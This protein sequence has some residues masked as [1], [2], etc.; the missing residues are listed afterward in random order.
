MY[1]S[2]QEII[3]LEKDTGKSFWEIVRDND[4]RE[5]EITEEA[6]FQRMQE[7]YEAMRNA[8]ASYDPSLS[9]ASGLVGRDGEKVASARKTELCSAENFLA[10]LWKKPSKWASPTP[11]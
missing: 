5:M 8:D 7:M 1:Q 9:S 4:C 11:A 6:A 2:F 3:K 10:L